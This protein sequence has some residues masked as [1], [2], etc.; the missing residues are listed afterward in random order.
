MSHEFICAVII[1]PASMALKRW[2][3]LVVL[4]KGVTSWMLLETSLT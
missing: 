1:G 2:K 4:D 3:S